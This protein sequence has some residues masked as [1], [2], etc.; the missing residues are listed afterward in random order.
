MANNLF[1]RINAVRKILSWN[2]QFMPFFI[3][4]N[5]K[6]D[7][8]DHS[9]RLVIM[10]IAFC[11]LWT[12][13]QCGRCYCYMKRDRSNLVPQSLSILFMRSALNTFLCQ[14]LIIHCYTH[15]ACRNERAW[16]N[17]MHEEQLGRIRTIRINSGSTVSST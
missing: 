14:P 4:L 7:V 16:R 1:L 8:F 10:G 6:H 5:K 3:Y 15:H 12:A 13:S 2:R 17:R 11:V 9:T